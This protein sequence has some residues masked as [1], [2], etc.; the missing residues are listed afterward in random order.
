MVNHH[1]SIDNDKCIVCGKCVEV[2][3]SDAQHYR[4]DEKAV[5]KLLASDKKVY[6]SLAP[7]FISEIGMP[8]HEF[9][10][11]L[12]QLGF[13]GISETALG[14]QLVTYHQRESLSRLNK[15]QFSTA[16]PT[17]V[18]T[19]LKYF[20][21]LKKHLSQQLSP[22]LSHCKMLRKLYGEDIAI[23][24]AGPCIAKKLEAQSHP[25]LLDIAITFEELLNILN[26]KQTSINIKHN[27]GF[28]PCQSNGG[29]IY[30][31]DGGMNETITNLVSNSVTNTSFFNYSGINEIISIIKTE[32]FDNKSVF[33]EFLACKGGCINGSGLSDHK[34][35]ISRREK[36]SN[37]FKSLPKYSETSFIDKYDVHINENY[38][39]CKPVEVTYHSQEELN[40][41]YL[42]LGK[43]KKEDFLNCGGCGYNSCEEFAH[44]YLDNQSESSMCVSSMRKLASN[45]VKALMKEIP[46]GLSIIDKD[47][48]IVECNNLFLQISVETDIEVT[49]ELIQRVSGTSIDKFYN[50]SKFI[51][52]VFTSKESMNKTIKLDD[53]ILS[54]SLFIFGDNN[55][56]GAIIQDITEPAMNKDLVIS[57]AQKV[58]KNNL[59]TIQKIAFLLGE[60]ASETEITL[61]EIIQAYKSNK[62]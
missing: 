3:P 35:I 9:L 38:V 13:T 51:N 25:E 4:N 32:D 52:S 47:L 46:L 6:L 41:V 22:L 60:T 5:I 19:I 54:V 16:C 29:A 36:I 43:Y 21:E 62:V 48:K 30:P 39:F 57:K 23:V 44:A 33:C 27:V 7:S 40:N 28:I 37:Y 24:F 18:H 55:L 50:I 42:K 58:I 59:M 53:K 49:D 61:N 56:V 34:H 26:K 11:K 45:K 1:A 12:T 10:S 20:P 14:A 2:C 31:L 8:E 15:T 17:F